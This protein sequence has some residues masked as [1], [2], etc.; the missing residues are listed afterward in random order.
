MSNDSE[1]RSRMSSDLYPGVPVVIS[2]PSGVGKTTVKE[3]LLA[4]YQDLGASVSATTRDQREG[5][6]DGKDY[7]FYTTEQFKEDIHKGMFLEW[8]L[9][10]GNHYGTPRGPIEEKMEKGID[11]LLIIDIQGGVQVKDLYPEALLI[12]LLPPSMGELQ[13]RIS[14]RGTETIE[15]LRSRLANA[16]HEIS[17]ARYYD[18]WVINRSLDETVAQVRS[19]IV[20]D[21]C[22]VDRAHARY[23][24]LGYDWPGLE[25]L[26]EHR[27]PDPAS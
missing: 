23:K 8:A 4:R 7:Y 10:H 15:V 14:D 25:T 24:Q 16:E 13:Q 22:R 26:D 3:Q 17:Y 6:V 19:I 20:G 1:N 2:G 21:R 9:V 11:I 18:Y 12:F 27:S 5:E